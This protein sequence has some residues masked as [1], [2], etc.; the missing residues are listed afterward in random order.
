MPLLGWAM[1]A[2]IPIEPDHLCSL[3]ALNAGVTR[4]DTAFWGGI[5]WGIGHSIGM[6]TFC[7][8]FLSAQ[9]LI[10][11]ELWEFYGN[12]VAG[13]LLFGIGVYFLKHESQYVEIGED[14]DWKPT[15]DSCHCCSSHSVAKPMHKPHSHADG[16]DC[17]AGSC[18]HGSHDDPEAERVPLIAAEEK[19]KTAAT[20]IAPSLGDLRGAVVGTLQGLC[21]PSCVAGLAF[22]GQMGAQHPSTMDITLFFLIVFLSITFSSAVVSSL[23]VFA[24]RSASTCFSLS[25][26]TMFRA[27]CIF[28]ILVGITWIALNAWGQLHVIQYTHSIEERFHHGAVAG[29]SGTADMGNM[30]MQPVR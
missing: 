30:H 27:A 9:K 14:G 25:T 8:I 17:S 20:L 26:R 21:C 4:V 7:L 13:V 5:K 28:S 16:H 23:V 19:T 3:I 11:L 1:G 24:G 10:N 22:V 2:L 29:G 12:Y 18:S 6:L 15:S